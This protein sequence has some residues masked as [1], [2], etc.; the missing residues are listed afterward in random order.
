LALCAEFGVYEWFLDRPFGGQN[1]NS[2]D[3]CR[4]Y[5]A[6][7]AACLTTTF[8][9]TQFMG[10]CQRIAAGMHTT[11]AERWLPA[12]LA[13]K[14]F[15]TVGISHLTTSRRHLLRPVLRAEPSGSALVLDGY[16]PWV[17]GSDRA[18]VFVVGA[19]LDDGRQVLVAVPATADGITVPP[20]QSLVALN[21]SRTGTVEFHGV[22]VPDEW[23]LVGPAEDAMKR[24]SGANTGGLQTS[25]VAMGL[26]ASALEFLAHEAQRRSDLGEPAAALRGE[27]ETLKQ[28]LLRVAAGDA[29]CSTEQIRTRANSL[30]LRATQAALVAAK[31][32]GF[33]AS[34]PAGRW[35][36]EALFFLVW[37]CPQN[38]LASHLC[39]LAGIVDD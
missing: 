21:A 39:E 4:G 9:I 5:L 13:G 12:L 31:G 3:I 29:I 6:L 17:T 24:G 11:I 18:D 32:A 16:C 37:S 35:C 28:E 20:P 36:R 26:A 2:A 22:R 15:A 33:V 25:V 30:V 34:H 1:W 27:W 7:S 14:A 38:V 10:A 19:A 23:L 8:V